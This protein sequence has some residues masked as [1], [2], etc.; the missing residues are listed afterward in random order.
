MVMG[1]GIVPKWNFERF[2]IKFGLSRNIGLFLN[3]F[4]KQSV[5]L[6]KVPTQS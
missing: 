4:C 6:V 5:E 1:V 2:G 3:T